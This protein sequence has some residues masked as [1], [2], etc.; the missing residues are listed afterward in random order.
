MS[1]HFSLAV[2]FLTS[3]ACGGG[4]SGD[5]TPT[6]PPPPP[7]PNVVVVD[8]LDNRFDPKQIEVDPG[9]T[10]RWVN[11]GN[12]TNH[13]TTAMSMEW[14][15]GFV[16]LAVGDTFEHTFTQDDDG[17]TFEYSCLT[18]KD[19]CEMQGSVRVGASAPP[20]GPGY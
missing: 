2:A 15:S 16:F 12:E 4:G 14:S 8:I 10:V 5:S 6:V 1:K 13:T 3:L 19:C 11:R 9:T 18:H 7:A 17:Q 20:P